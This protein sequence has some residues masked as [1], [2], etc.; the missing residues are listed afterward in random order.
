MDKF[1][2]I[3]CHTCEQPIRAKLIIGEPELLDG[4]HGECNLCGW[5]FEPLGHINGLNRPTVVFPTQK[6]ITGP[7]EKAVIRRAG[8]VIILTKRNTLIGPV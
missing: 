1:K 6:I 3:K 2:N 7:D 5:N 8:P 4:Y